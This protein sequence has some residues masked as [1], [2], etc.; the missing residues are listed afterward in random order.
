MFKLKAYPVLNSR[1]EWTLKVVADDGDHRVSAMVP[2]GGSTS[3]KAAVYLHDIDKS[4]RLVEEVIYPAVQEASPDHPER[5][6]A[7]MLK[8]DGTKDKSVLGVEAM[9]AV[10]MAIYRLAAARAYQPLYQFLAGILGVSGLSFP[11]LFINLINGGAHADQAVDFQEY[12]L[13]PLKGELRE[14]LNQSITIQRRLK[15][16]IIK[17][18]QT[19]SYG[20][21]GGLRLE[22]KDNRRPLEWLAEAVESAGFKLGQDFVFGLDLAANNFFSQVGYSLR[23]F[24][25]PLDYNSL[26]EYYRRLVKDFPIRFLED[27]LAEADPHWSSLKDGL[28]GEKGWVKIVADDLIA[29][30]H[31]ILES[32]HKSVGFQAVIV[33]PNQVG[34][35]TETLKFIKLAR[36]LGLEL[37][38]SHRS[39]ET[40]DDFVADLAV[41]AQA[42]YVKF[43]VL[44]Q[45]D[46]LSKYNRLLVIKANH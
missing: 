10:S 40:C 30:N 25:K 11:R 20:D 43:G 7:L 22:L 38:V 23:E 12:H 21:E 33:K 27:P 44:R 35:V 34:T 46:R 36:R 45:S 16:L 39:G 28:V 37:V 41:A 32:Y 42:E 1:A 19:V 4:A 2:S 3:H 26:I 8:L 17:T 29:T 18:G 5:I 13:I 14:Q 6:D 31:G 15:E 24:D 9:L